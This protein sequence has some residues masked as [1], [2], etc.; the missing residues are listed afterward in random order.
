MEDVLHASSGAKQLLNV[1]LLSWSRSPWG[2]QCTHHG[3]GWNLIMDPRPDRQLFQKECL[4]F[5]DCFYLRMLNTG[6]S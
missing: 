2:G 5:N 3:T 4:L 6:L 1:T